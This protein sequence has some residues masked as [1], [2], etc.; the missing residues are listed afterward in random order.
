MT[1]PVVPVAPHPPLSGYYQSP[2]ERSTFVR[3][4]FD[5]TARHYD[6]INL[7][8]CFGSGNWYRRRALRRAGL[9]P[10]QR[11]LDIATGTGLLARQ[12]LA[13]AGEAADVTGIDISESMLAV[14]RH[15]LDIPLIQGRAEQ[16]PIEGDSVDF[17]CMG[18]GL[19]H[20]P[21]LMPTFAEFYRVLRPSG[22][23]LLLEMSKPRAQWYRDFVSLYLGRIVPYLCGRLT[24]RA[25]ARLL[26]EY[27]WETIEHCVSPKVISEALAKTGFEAIGCQEDLDLFRAYVGRKPR[28]KRS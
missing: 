13:L 19:R 23:V 1:E 22:T 2:A 10:G 6:G 4:L 27:Y 9:R 20:V 17:L 24:A 12:A 15:N 16:L 8:F 7:F 5:R 21:D 18:Y 3:Q 11:V 28:D 25:D 26:M 14:A